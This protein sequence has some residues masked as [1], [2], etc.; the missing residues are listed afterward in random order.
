MATKNTTR[1]YVLQKYSDYVSPKPNASH[2]LHEDT[3]HLAL[4]STQITVEFSVRIPPCLRVQM[5]EVVSFFGGEDRKLFWKGHKTEIGIGNYTWF[6]AV[7]Y[8]CC[9]SS[10]NQIWFHEVIF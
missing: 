10:G 7:R 9:C 4:A 6:K 2:T 1:R 5:N 8:C 3:W